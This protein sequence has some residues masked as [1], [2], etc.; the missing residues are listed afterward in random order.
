MP[1]QNLPLQAV[2]LGL[3]A[4]PIGAFDDDAVHELLRLPRN[5]RPVY[6]LPVVGRARPWTCDGDLSQSAPGR[7]HSA[8][9][10]ETARME[11]APSPF[12]TEEPGLWTLAREARDAHLCIDLRGG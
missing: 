12:G 2:A 11:D 3:G 1:G 8:A 7:F 6:L 10:A 5:Q 4:V 9:G